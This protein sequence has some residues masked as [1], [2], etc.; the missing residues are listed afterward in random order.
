MA[1]AQEKV[2]ALQDSSLGFLEWVSGE[3]DSEGHLEKL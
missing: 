3:M 2:V 1:Q